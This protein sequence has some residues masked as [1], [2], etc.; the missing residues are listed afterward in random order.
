M[1]ITDITALGDTLA[2]KWSDS[3]EGYYLL[4]TLRKACPCAHCQGEPDVLGNVEKPR[5]K[6]LD[7]SAYIMKM[8]E[9]IGTYALKITWGD[10]HSTGLYSYDYLRKLAQI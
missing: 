7:E 5:L 9:L 1:T 2:I 10:N 8:Y 4:K 3:E 6:E